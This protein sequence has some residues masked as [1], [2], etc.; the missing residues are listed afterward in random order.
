MTTQAKIATGLLTAVIAAGAV[1]QSPTLTKV[2]PSAVAASVETPTTV[3][4]LPVGRIVS[5]ETRSG[6]PVSFKAVL[7]T[8]PDG[9]VNT[10]QTDTNG[11]T[12]IGGDIPGI[13]NAT[14]Y[15]VIYPDQK[16]EGHVLLPETDKAYTLA[17]TEAGTPMEFET[18]KASKLLC[19][20]LPTTPS[21]TENLEDSEVAAIVGA[22]GITTIGSGPIPVFDSK[23]KATIQLYMEFG[24]ATVLDPLWNG[25]KTIVAPPASLTTQQML[26]IC[27]VV[28][29][30][31]SPFNVNITTDINKYNAA[32]AGL[33]TR[34]I[35]TT[36]PV[37]SKNFAWAGSAGGLSWTNSI[38]RSGRGMSATIPNWVFTNR[39][40]PE[41]NTGEAIAHEIGHSFNLQHKGQGTSP[42]YYG[43]ATW[44]PIMGV[45]YNKP[46][47]QWSKG[48]YPLA[49]NVTDEVAVISQYRDAGLIPPVNA[50]IIRAGSQNFTNTLTNKTVDVYTVKTDAAGVLTVTAKPTAFSAVNTKMEIL[51]GAQ[52][53][54]STASPL[55]DQGSAI[56]NLKL[57]PYQTYYIRISGVAEIGQYPAY[58]SL[59]NYTLTS[60]LK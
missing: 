1:I 56:A 60:T 22:D 12:R 33:R 46:I 57:A 7:P 20:G 48:E 5:T 16:V 36:I 40:S 17:P 50:D 32:G 14:F 37:G 41:K 45:G 30:R 2:T 58:G 15:F 10:V 38:A 53:I 25:G 29:E 8:I 3:N 26:T 59:G 9:I 34:T 13:K 39:T 23:P 28:G 43:T 51:D 52:K 31:Y 11:T 54:L 44:A 4:L 55:G 47:V 6:T 18:Q 19:F 21:I 35:I 27:K 42:Y 24:G 49:N